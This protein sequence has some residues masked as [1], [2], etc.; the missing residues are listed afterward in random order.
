MH[1]DGLFSYAT[2]F[3]FLFTL[4]RVSCVFAF[5]PLA[6]FRGTPDVP[7][8]FLSLA[9]TMVLW[10][11][12]KGPVSADAS[13]GR[14]V[15]G[16]AGE[17]AIG[18][19]IGL[20]LAIV[21]EVFQIAA[22]VVSIQAGFGF[23][24]TI[25]PNSGADSTVLLSLAQITAG[26]LFF[27][28]GADRLLVR[29]LADSLRLCPPES[30]IVKKS[31]AEALIRFAAS[32]FGSGLRLAAPVVALLMLTDAA[33]AVLGRVQAQIQLVTLTMPAKLAASMLLLAATL[34]FQ[35]KFF[36]SMMTQGIRLIEGMLRSGH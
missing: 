19:A 11:E 18:F 36:G 27:A 33:L 6:A 20:A 31:W 26:L 30:F 5:V 12:W 24:S 25:D 22:Q 2:L 28:T 4:A 34:V 9:F 21:L 15:A 10:P 7:K 29:A 16:L 14:I 3:G 23:A 32:I 17:A 1:A 13:I 8:V 35:P